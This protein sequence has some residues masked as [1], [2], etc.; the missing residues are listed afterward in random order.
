VLDLYLENATMFIALAFYKQF[1][2][3]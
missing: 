3:H 2:V 1:Y